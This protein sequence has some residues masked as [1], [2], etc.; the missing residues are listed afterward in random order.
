MVAIYRSRK[1]CR[2]R[3]LRRIVSAESDCFLLPPLTRLACLPPLD[4]KAWLMQVSAGPRQYLAPAVLLSIN[5]CD[6]FTSASFPFKTSEST[7]LC[8]RN[9]CCS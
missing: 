5:M 9:F 1:S 8:S 7:Q 6:W 2:Q 3:N 4:A